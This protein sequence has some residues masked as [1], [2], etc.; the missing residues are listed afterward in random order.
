MSAIAGP[1]K[2]HMVYT[3]PSGQH[4]P[5]AP[6]Q[7]FYHPPPQPCYRP[8]PQQPYYPAQRQQ[9]YRPPQQQKFT[10]RAP[11]QQQGNQVAHSAPPA[12]LTNP[13]VCFNCGKTG[14]FAKD[15]KYPM[16]NAPNQQGANANQLRGQPQWI[17]HVNYTN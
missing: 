5:I 12:G 13:Q 2:Y 14:H 10:P 16:K 11:F 3:S 17:G 4:F 6:Q 7:N 15:C 9:L 1:H 8:P